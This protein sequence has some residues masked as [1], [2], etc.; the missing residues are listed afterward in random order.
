MTPN[1]SR[2]DLLLP[3]LLVG[4]LGATFVW[5]APSPE[6]DGHNQ[7][8][9]QRIV[10][11]D[12]CA[13]QYV[14]KLAAP[15]HIVALSPDATAPYSYMR[16]QA[17]AYPKV[18]PRA[19]DVLSLRPDLVVRAYGGGSHIKGPLKRAGVPVAQL[20]F[21]QDI[22]GIRQATLDV[23]T[24]LQVL[25]KGRALVQEMD[26]R[27]AAIEAPQPPVSALYLTPAGVTTGPDT[28]IHTLLTRAGLQNF[29]T[30]SGWNPI[31]LEKLAYQQ[32]DLVVTAYN[33]TPTNHVDAWSTMRHP[34]ARQQTRNRPTLH[35]DPSHIACGAWFLVDAVESL[36]DRAT[37]NGQR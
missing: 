17:A 33:D 26:R 37:P 15:E 32:P 29:Q 34:I 7:P 11:V 13:D 20:P 22:E 30:S 35:L 16:K 14:L 19:E 18:R 9:P 5:P 10:S 21:A 23:A 6:P 1:A 25:P 27:L 8:A 24:S 31:P 3:L 12:F 28:L 4:L 36:A 2:P